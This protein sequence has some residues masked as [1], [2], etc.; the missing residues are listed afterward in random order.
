M[1]RCESRFDSTLRPRIRGACLEVEIATPHNRD[2]VCRHRVTADMNAI[3]TIIRTAIGTA[4]GDAA[5]VAYQTGSSITK[6]TANIGVAVIGE[7]PYAE[8]MGDVA[9]QA[10]LTIST[11]DQNTV[12]ALKTAGLKVVVVLVTGRPML[13]P[14]SLVDSADAIV[15][16]WLPGS[17][18]DGVADVLFGDYK[19]TGKLP[20]S[21]P[22]TWAQIPINDG[23]PTYSPLYAYGFGLTY[24]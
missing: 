3:G 19:P 21:W 22:A 6:G 2:Y 8:T 18:G 11:T 9:T 5:K 1:L 15:E 14:Q 12:V 16:A 4:L 13:L 23:D 17:E 24:P 10:A 7:A 20:H